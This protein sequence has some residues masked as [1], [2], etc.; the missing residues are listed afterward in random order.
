MEMIICTLT[1]FTK[2]SPDDTNCFQILHEKKVSKHGAPSIANVTKQMLKKENKKAANI[3]R[4][5]KLCKE[6]V[7][8]T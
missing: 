3:K 2:W 4:V 5:G 8:N 7:S 6:K 1:Y